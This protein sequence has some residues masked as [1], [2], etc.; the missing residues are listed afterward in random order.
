MA[1]RPYFFGF[2]S[3]SKF[4]KDV[5]KGS[6]HAKRQ[7]SLANA[8][9]GVINSG[10]LVIHKIGHGLAKERGLK[11]LVSVV[12]IRPE[13]PFKINGLAANKPGF[14]PKRP[15]FCPPL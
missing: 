6:L 2:K 12:Q 15:R 14:P 11:I 8:A 13:A 10:S 7:L 4:V 9:L 1:K 5:F 3:I